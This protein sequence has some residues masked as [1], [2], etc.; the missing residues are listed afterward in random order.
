MGCSGQWLRWA[1]TARQER[2]DQHGISRN[3]AGRPLRM[4][5]VNG[6]EESAFSARFGWPGLLVRWPWDVL[7]QLEIYRAEPERIARRTSPLQTVSTFPA[8]NSTELNH[9]SRVEKPLKFS[10]FIRRCLNVWR[11]GAKSPR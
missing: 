3:V 2:S 9:S 8:G 1:G 7:L 5:L 4:A 11:S 10:R 6:R